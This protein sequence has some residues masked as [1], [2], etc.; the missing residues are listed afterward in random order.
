MTN[1]KGN[2]YFWIDKEIMKEA[3]KNLN[4]KE[5]STLIDA[6][7]QYFNDFELRKIPQKPKLQKKISYYF[8]QLI[9]IPENLSGYSYES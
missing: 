5:L 9:N 4:T 1:I 8:E 2:A 7:F 3:F 6:L